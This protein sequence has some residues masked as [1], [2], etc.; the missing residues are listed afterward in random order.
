M[1]EVVASSRARVWRAS[2]ICRSRADFCSS[3]AKRPVRCTV[4]GVQSPNESVTATTSRSDIRSSRSR[5]SAQA[6]RRGGTPDRR[7]V[8]NR[9]LRD[10]VLAAVG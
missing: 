2:S 1:N 3:T 10:I 7:A 9:A 6:L 4:I 5:Y 8:E